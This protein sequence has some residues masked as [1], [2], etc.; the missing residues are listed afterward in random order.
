MAGRRQ[1]GLR[2]ARVP[3]CGSRS[4]GQ[5]PRTSAVNRFLQSWDVHNIFVAGAS[6]FPQNLQ[7]NPTGTVGGLTYW[8][9]DALRRDYLKNPRA[10]VKGV[11][12]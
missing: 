10:L 5:P 7:F 11:T 8:M 4:L 9:V 3:P 12:P 2:R 6:A 1:A